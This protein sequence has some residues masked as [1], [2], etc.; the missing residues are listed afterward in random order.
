MTNLSSDHP[1]PL[2]RRLL[3]KPSPKVLGLLAG[4]LLLTGGGIWAIA[5]FWSHSTPGEITATAPAIAVQTL[6]IKPQAIAQTLTFSGTVRPIQQATLSTRVSGR[7]IY[8]PVEAGDRVRKGQVLAR[9]NV[10]D[11][12]AQTHQAEA[13]VAQAQANLAQAQAGVAQAQA[14]LNQQLAQRLDA[15]SALKLARIEQHRMAQLLSEGVVAQQQLDLANTTLEQ[16]Q[17]KLAQV[18]ANIHQARATIAQ[19]Q[20]AIAQSQAAIQQAEAGVTAASI[21]QSYGTI[22]APFDGIVTAK[23]AYEGETTNP[24]SMNGT[25]LLKLENSHRLQLEVTVPEANR[26]D[27]QV[28]Q[29]VQVT[30]GSTQQNISG[31][32]AQIIPAADPTSRSFIVKIPLPLSPTLMSGMF[33]RVELPIPGQR[34]TIAIPASVLFR[35]GQLEGV[36]IVGTHNQAEIR[37]VKTGKTQNGQVE[38]VSGLSSGDRIIT[39][40]EAQLK[41]GQPIVI[42][43]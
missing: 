2:K 23:M 14:A 25:E 11:I 33:G 12:V 34:Q 30:V 31:A 17:A 37:W 6:V 22:R 7:I 10:L 39:S 43:R 5:Q 24:F 35:R 3:T 38:I 36:Y 9:I 20:A 16:A 28:G 26:E 40:K 4:G 32:I 21:N 42:Q 19:S 15:Q 18:E 13:G 27:V 41:D 8:L 29:P 1:L